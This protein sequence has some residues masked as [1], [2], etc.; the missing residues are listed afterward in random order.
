MTGLQSRY[1]LAT[2]RGVPLY[3]HTSIIILIAI[4]LYD[5]ADLMGD[6]GRL[7]LA[8]SFVVMH[9]YGHV[10]TARKFGVPTRDVVLYPFGGVASLRGILSP[11]AEFWVAL[12]GPAVNVLIALCLYPFVDFERLQTAH[13]LTIIEYAF[14]I[15]CI[16]PAFNMIPAFPMDGGRA[17]RALLLILRIPGATS[18]AATLGGIIGCGFAIYALMIQAPI[19]FLVGVVVCATAFRELQQSRALARNGAG[20]YD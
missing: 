6:F 16:L 14:V 2:V 8:L 13:S 10:L 1:H 20:L 3:I 7:L 15:N 18:I 12:G 4:V 19:L 9:E 5:S 17:L 11:V